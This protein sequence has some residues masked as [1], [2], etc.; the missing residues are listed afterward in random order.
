MRTIESTKTFKVNTI[1]TQHSKDIADR[2][3]NQPNNS[4]GVSDQSKTSTEQDEHT[5]KITTQQ[6]ETIINSIDL[7]GLK[8]EERE[9]VKDLL[10]EQIMYSVFPMMT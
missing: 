5:K 2:N 6:Q 8:H 4:K 1:T 3:H 9:Q 7:S 10:R